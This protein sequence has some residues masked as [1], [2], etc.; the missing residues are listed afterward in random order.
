MDIQTYLVHSKYA[1]TANPY[2]SLSKDCNIQI[3]QFISENLFHLR[4]CKFCMNTF[5]H[6]GKSAFKVH[7]R[8]C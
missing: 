6:L 7:Y 8:K 5:F 3:T 1:F 4:I 2:V